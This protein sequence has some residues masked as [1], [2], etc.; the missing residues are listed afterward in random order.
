[1]ERAD[2]VELGMRTVAD[3]VSRAPGDP[4]DTYALRLTSGTSGSGPVMVVRQFDPVQNARYYADASDIIAA[5]FGSRSTRL[6]QAM[7]MRKSGA[8]RRHMLIL[9]GGDVTPHIDTLLQ[10]FAP[11]ALL[12]LPSVM[13][14][15][16]SRMPADVRRGVK[17]IVA[18]GEH[19]GAAAQKYFLQ[20]Y[21]HARIDTFYGS[22]E[23]G[24]VAGACP[25]D[26]TTIYHPLPNTFIEIDDPDKDGVGDI[27]VTKTIYRDQKVRRYRIGDMG[28]IIDGPCR[29]GESVSFEVVGRTGYDYIKLAGAILRREEFDRV[30]LSLGE[31]ISDY[32]AEA[33]IAGTVE[34]SKGGIILSVFRKSSVLNTSE[35]E[36]VRVLFAERLFISTTLTLAQAVLKGYFVPLEVVAVSQ[37]FPKQSKDVT[38]RLR[39]S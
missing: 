12:G 18:G 14:K 6:T 21:P 11:D 2:V 34:E 7:N 8:L 35:L 27:L 17:V 37:P 30:A 15:I 16:S 10:Q 5:F 24:V 31:Y 29:C 9:D 32:R 4:A 36:Q 20:Q 26:P 22:S 19:V 13:V 39:P 28:K 25:Y 38:L 1:M 3:F 23:V 33:Y